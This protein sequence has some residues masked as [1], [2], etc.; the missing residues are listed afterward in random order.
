MLVS[1]VSICV[2][3]DS[4]SLIDVIENLTASG[5]R[6]SLVVDATHTLLGIVSDGDVRRALLR[7]GALD[8]Q[9]TEIMNTDFI[10][11]DSFTDAAS[12]KQLAR[13]QKVMHLPLMGEN[14]ELEGLYID[15]PTLD[16]AVRENTV[17][18]MAGGRGLRLRPLTD[19]TPK[20]MLDVA[21]KP[22]V[23]HTIEALRLEGFSK[24]ILAIN[25]LGEQ[26]EDHFGD[27]SA[28]GVQL[29]YLKEETPLGTGGA[30]SLLGDSFR[31][32]LLV[33]NGDVLVSARLSSMVDYHLSNR[34]DITVGVKLLDTQIP[35]GVVRIEGARITAIEEKPTYR[36]FVNAGV[37]VIEPALLAPLSPGV[38]ID[39][40]DLVADWLIKSEVLAFP[41]HEQWRDLGHFEDL[42]I[43]R[44]QYE[45]KGG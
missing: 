27:G 16:L 2:V 33:V 39:M 28:L 14:R 23:Q 32:P 38:R 12:L 37:Y 3:S 7:D 6:I 30:L 24:F 34:A 31:S 10:F 20:P 42:E 43:A 26:I 21:G 35:F 25:H 13:S 18:I 5:L 29:S 40:P 9:A 45:G 4:A 1:D 19:V 11:A 22:M 17:V 44:K 8:S 36:D 15:D 41:I